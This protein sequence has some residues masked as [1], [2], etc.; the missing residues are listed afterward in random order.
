MLVALQDCG[1]LLIYYSHTY[2]SYLILID[3]NNLLIFNPKSGQ[4][5]FTKAAINTR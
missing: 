2:K 4:Y 5:V 1:S 3:I